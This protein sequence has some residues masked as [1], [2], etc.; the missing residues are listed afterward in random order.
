MCI[1]IDI[2]FKELCQEQCWC[3]ALVMSLRAG[4]RDCWETDRTRRGLCS[5]QTF[6]NGTPLGLASRRAFDGEAR[7][8]SLRDRKTETRKRLFRRMCGPWWRNALSPVGFF[9]WGLSA[10]RIVRFSVWGWSALWTAHFSVWGWSC[11]SLC[12][13]WAKIRCLWEKK[14]GKLTGYQG[15]AYKV[16]LVDRTQS[17]CQAA[18]VWVHVGTL[19]SVNPALLTGFLA[20]RCM[21]SSWSEDVK[22]CKHAAIRSCCCCCF[23]LG[24]GGGGCTGRSWIL[25]PGV[26]SHPRYKSCIPHT[27]VNMVLNV[28]RNHTAY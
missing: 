25:C 1:Y 27:Q 12:A 3:T 7:P 26:F 9:A 18:G 21:V 5:E 20:S 22:V 11:D 28:H 10:L 2:L 15:Q 16:C 17:P 14:G 8:F 24:E 13:G 23:L 4:L 6:P 19:D